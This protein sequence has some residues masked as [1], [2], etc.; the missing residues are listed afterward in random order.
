MGNL[1]LRGFSLCYSLRHEQP[2]DRAKHHQLLRPDV[3]GGP[4][5]EQPKPPKEVVMVRTT[6]GCPTKGPLACGPPLPPGFLIKPEEAL[7]GQ[8]GKPSPKIQVAAVTNP[9]KA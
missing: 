8:K 4:A 2:G 9:G 5:L 3:T 1:R 6:G 7:S